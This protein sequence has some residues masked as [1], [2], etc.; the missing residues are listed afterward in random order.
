MPA[1]ITF[2]P[3]ATA[4]AT[5]ATANSV[6]RLTKSVAA[7]ILWAGGTGYAKRDRNLAAPEEAMLL[8][9]HLSGGVRDGKMQV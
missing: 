7:C 4:V 6:E 8:K 2:A 1:R 3:N 5:A 9:V